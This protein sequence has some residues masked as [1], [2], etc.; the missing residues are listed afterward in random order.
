MKFYLCYDIQLCQ[1]RVASAA[2]L[3]D[4]HAGCRNSV[5]FPRYSYGAETLKFVYFH[6]DIDN[7]YEALL[8]PR[9][10]GNKAKAS[11]T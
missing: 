10:G 7:A 9:I 2:L 4:V 3:R 11:C 8:Y 5:H 6:A 1:T